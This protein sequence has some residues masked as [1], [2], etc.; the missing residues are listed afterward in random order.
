MKF[1]VFHN[2]RA[3]HFDEYIMSRSPGIIGRV[4][5]AKNTLEA[6]EAIKNYINSMGEYTFYPND[7]PKLI[8]Y[9][10]SDVHE[11]RYAYKVEAYDEAIR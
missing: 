5:K 7:D 4:R 6:A 2:V 8:M 10:V 1:N 11:P 9:S 3:G